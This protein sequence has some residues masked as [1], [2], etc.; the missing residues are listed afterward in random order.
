VDA[1]D[2]F[3]SAKAVKQLHDRIMATIPFEDTIIL[4]GCEVSAVTTGPDTL[5]I[6]AGVVKM[7]NVIIDSPAYAGAYPVWLKPDATYVNA[8]PGA[9]LFIKFDPYSSQGFKAVKRR[10]DYDSGAVIMFNVDIGDFPGGVGKWDWLGWK[11]CDDMQSRVPLGYDRRS[12]DPGDGFWDANYNG[13]GNTGGA[14][15]AVLV[16][17]QLPAVINAKLPYVQHTSSA[18]TYGA[19]DGPVSGGL[20]TVDIAITNT[21]GGQPLSKVQPYRVFKYLERQ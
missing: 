17:N 14:K 5:A 6:A 2:V 9:G 12:S 15:Q 10:F 20:P 8:A 13:V 11:I 21:G 3:A 19:T 16:Q 18:G 4:K 7:G 1:S